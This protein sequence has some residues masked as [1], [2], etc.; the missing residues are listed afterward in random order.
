MEILVSPPLSLNV[1]NAAP[2]LYYNSRKDWIY[3]DR[4]SLDNVKKG[5]TRQ[6]LRIQA[7]TGMSQKKMITSHRNS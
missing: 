2:F 1:Q 7:K 5:D 6:S 3:P 4:G